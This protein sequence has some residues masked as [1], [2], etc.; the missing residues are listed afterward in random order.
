MN[1]KERERLNETDE[2][3]RPGSRQK[4]RDRDEPDEGSARAL[5]A[6]LIQGGPPARGVDLLRIF[7]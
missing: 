7:L 5:A 4:A 1:E 6:A 2:T 3:R